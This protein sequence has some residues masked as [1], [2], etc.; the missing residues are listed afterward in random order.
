MNF[1]SN[2]GVIYSFTLGTYSVSEMNISIC[3]LKYK[4]NLYKSGV[5]FRL[6]S[7]VDSYRINTILFAGGDLIVDVG[8]NIGELIYCF[9]NQRYI[10]FEPSPQEFRSLTLNAGSNC[11]I[12]NYAIGSENKKAKFF[13]S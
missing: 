6:N 12:F 13:S 4:G 3:F 8:A 5:L 9:P 10:G 11:R 2:K 7:L 1:V